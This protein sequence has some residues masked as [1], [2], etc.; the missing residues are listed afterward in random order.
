VSH[1]RP[2]AAWVLICRPAQDPDGE[3]CYEHYEH[4]PIMRGDHSRHAGAVRA[5]IRTSFAA[6]RHAGS[7]WSSYD[8]DGAAIFSDC[9]VEVVDGPLT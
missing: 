2:G 3:G 7:W 8:I 1:V 9:T 4:E 5:A 6:H